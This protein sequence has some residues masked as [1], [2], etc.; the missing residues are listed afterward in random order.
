MC[1]LVTTSNNKVQGYITEINEVQSKIIEE[2]DKLI[3]FSVNVLGIEIIINKN[4]L[5]YLLI[6]WADT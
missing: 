3:F 4:L 5:L 2:H 6:S 1:L